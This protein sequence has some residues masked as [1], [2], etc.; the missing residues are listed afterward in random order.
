MKQEAKP[1]HSRGGKA[2]ASQRPR[3]R[4]LRKDHIT[5]VRAF[6]YKIAWTALRTDGASGRI[7]DYIRPMAQEF[8]R[9]E[10]SFVH[11]FPGPVAGSRASGHLIAV[12]GFAPE[13]VSGPGPPALSRPGRCG[14]TTAP[15]PAADST[16]GVYGSCGRRKAGTHP[17]TNGEGI[18]TGCLLAQNQ[19][20]IGRVFRDRDG[21]ISFWP[22]PD[23]HKNWRI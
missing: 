7:G 17:A 11:K 1:F 13:M 4:P 14:P 3:L 21:H 6:R 12:K 5:D 22:S 23:N 8:H 10:K 18:V 20:H 2:Q 9:C 16:G 19:P 15:L